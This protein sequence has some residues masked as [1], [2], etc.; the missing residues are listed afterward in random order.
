MEE[1]EAAIAQASEEPEGVTLASV[2][3]RPEPGLDLFLFTLSD[4]RRLS[5][6]RENLQAL[7]GS[8][9]LTAAEFEVSP[10]GTDVWWTPREDGVTLDGLLEGRY[11][12]DIWMENLRCTEPVA[13]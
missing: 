2:V 5:V 6:P 1:I 3:Y 8:T 10:F 9:P 12:N 7:Q 11:G 13:A 4:G